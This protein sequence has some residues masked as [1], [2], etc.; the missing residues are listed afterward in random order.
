M[1]S[2]DNAF[3]VE[4]IKN[5]EIQ[6]LLVKHHSINIKFTITIESAILFKSS[7][8]KYVV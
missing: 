8:I 4:E 2:A 7:N 5:M 6:I 1:K 3:H